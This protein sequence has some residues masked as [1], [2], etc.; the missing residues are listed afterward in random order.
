[1]DDK[2]AKIQSTTPQSDKLCNKKCGIYSSIAAVVIIVISG[3]ITGEI[4]V[5]KRIL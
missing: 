4:I 1:M 2:A 5:E 3:I